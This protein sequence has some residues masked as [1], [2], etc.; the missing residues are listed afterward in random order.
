MYCSKCGT[1]NSED[2][3][4][5]KKCGS[6]LNQN[7]QD[8]S[9]SRKQSSTQPRISYLPNSISDKLPSM[10][11]IELLKLTAEQQA[12]FVE[13]YR[14]KKKSVGL[15]YLLWF[16]IGLHY[17]YLGKIGWQIFYWLTLGG[18]LIWCFID[19]FRIPGMV[20]NYNKDIAIDV[21]RDLKMASA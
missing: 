1:Q 14:R 12:I 16:V 4:F 3:I 21:F 9:N 8:N 19:L 6:Q 2:D 5:C 11:K 17:I 15:A 18:F 13:E 20:N 7:S 10:V